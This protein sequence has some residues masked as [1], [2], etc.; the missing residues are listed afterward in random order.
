[1]QP[2]YGNI[3]QFSHEKEYSLNYD[4]YEINIYIYSSKS[5]KKQPNN[6][7]KECIIS[8]QYE[9]DFKSRSE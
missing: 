8:I 5:Y 4:N 9:H 6:N 3:L 2:Q 7:E 1:M